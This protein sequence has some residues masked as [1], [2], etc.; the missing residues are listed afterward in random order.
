[1]RKNLP[2]AL[3]MLLAII[4]CNNS[5]KPNG[6]DFGKIENEKYVNSY[7]AMEM[8]VPAGWKIQTQEQMENLSKEGE[9][10]LVGD[11][12][13]MKAIVKASEVN[14]ANLFAAYEHEVGSAVAYNP[15]LMLVAENIQKAPGIKTGND[16]LFQARK[17]LEQSQFRY[18]HLDQEFEKEVIN[19]MT[20]YKM[21]TALNY[22]DLLIK[23]TYYS[24]VIKGFS[25][26]VIISFVEEEQ[27][28]DLL[29]TINSLKFEN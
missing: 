11:D 17:L 8:D 7:F 9:K 12:K 2:W 1:M 15:N 19:G 25:F 24:T 26:N 21:N 23:Q 20:F 10:L 3:L 14:T 29:K 5:N 22:A 18:D 28:L 13:K 4:S 6:F 27:K 16:Y